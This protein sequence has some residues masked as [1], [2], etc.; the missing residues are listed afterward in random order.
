[1]FYVGCVIWIYPLLSLE[2]RVFLIPVWSFDCG[3]YEFVP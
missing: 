1:M 3:W 2:I